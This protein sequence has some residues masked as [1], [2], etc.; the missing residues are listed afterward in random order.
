[1]LCQNI[2]KLYLPN[3]RFHIFSVTSVCPS[4]CKCTSA[5]GYKFHK[6]DE[7]GNC[8]YWCSEHGYCGEKDTHKENGV[9]CRGCAGSERIIVQSK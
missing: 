5:S 9:D 2:T 4:S 6:V 3:I 8:N 7:N 1:M